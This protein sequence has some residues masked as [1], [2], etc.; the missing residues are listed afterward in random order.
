MCV[1]YA[2]KWIIQRGLSLGGWVVTYQSEHW[3]LAYDKNPPVYNNSNGKRF[4][5]AGNRALS[6]QHSNSA[7]LR[8]SIFFLLT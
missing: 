3:A 6:N 7:M 8:H 1:L 2:F 4:G 5:K